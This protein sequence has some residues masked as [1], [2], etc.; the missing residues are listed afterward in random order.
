MELIELKTSDKENSV[1]YLLKSNDNEI[2]YGYIFAKEINPIEIY[3]YENYQSNGYGK[4]LFNSLLN[5]LKNKG[6]K[7]ILFEI[8][9]SNYR[10]INIIGQAGAREFGRNSPIIKFVLKL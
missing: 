1:K 3:I 2:G 7:G 10:F 5:I 6:L 8:D 9:E 4:L